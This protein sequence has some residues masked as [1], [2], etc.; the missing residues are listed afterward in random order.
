MSAPDRFWEGLGAS[1]PMNAGNS[2]SPGVSS[3]DASVF[4]SQADLQRDRWSVVFNIY[5][6][7]SG[8]Q[9]SGHMRP[10]DAR[11]LGRQLL[12]AA[13][14]MEDEQAKYSTAAAPVEVA[15]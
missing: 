4:V 11:Q 15:P 10:D 9:F 13:D 6:H 8:F 14:L 5:S 3:A 1:T 7:L 2:I 12:D